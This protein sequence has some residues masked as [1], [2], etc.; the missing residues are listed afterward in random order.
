MGR[1]LS[2]LPTEF[3]YRPFLVREAVAAGIPKGRLSAIDLVA[4]AAGVRMPKELAHSGK[5][6]ALAVGL[7][8]GEHQRISGV[9]ALLLHDV[10]LPEAFQRGEAP[11]SVVS[12]SGAAPVRRRGV[13][14]R[15]SCD[16]RSTKVEGVR[17]STPSLAWFEARLTLT[18]DDL[19]IAGDHLV[20]VGGLA[21]CDD[22]RS[23]IRPRAA[24]AALARRALEAV[25]VGA[26]SPMET[27]LRLMLVR[28][29]F[30]EPELNIDVLDRNDVFLG[31]VD[32]LW[33]A[34]RV[35][36]EY[37]GSHHHLSRD[38]W[39]RDRKRSNGFVTEGWRIL[40]VSA[41]DVRSPSSVIQR[42]RELLASSAA[43]PGA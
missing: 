26:E 6:H 4:P 8:L 39:E 21:T 19:V 13:I 15:V 14:G 40:H 29:G 28:A 24:Q 5:A 18:H 20:Q 36:L 30:P 32:M 43:Q 42:L 2:N 35:G 25:R 38:A 23:A 11:V 27:K 34:L 37:D 7:L 41:Q 17:C 10:P 16:A 1:A 3:R 9:S 33:P 12:W 31:R 22:L